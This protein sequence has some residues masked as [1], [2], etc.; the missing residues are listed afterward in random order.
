M[1]IPITHFVF[2]FFL[3]LASVL[4]TGRSR[5]PR[6]AAQKPFKRKRHLRRLSFILTLIIAR[7]IT[8]F[9]CIVRPVSFKLFPVFSVTSINTSYRRRKLQAASVVME[10]LDGGVSV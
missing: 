10:I 7:R 2:G 6:S 5:A 8:W 3:T 1:C 9:L 4:G